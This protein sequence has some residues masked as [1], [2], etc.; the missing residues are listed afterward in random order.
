MAFSGFFSFVGVLKRKRETAV[1][2]RLCFA[3][4]YFYPADNVTAGE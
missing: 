3:R 1:L 4:R 2:F